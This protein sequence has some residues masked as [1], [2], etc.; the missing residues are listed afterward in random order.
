MTSP[1]CETCGK[2]YEK[3]A[4][5]QFCSSSFHCC[6]DCTWKAG[7][8]VMVCK[9]CHDRDVKIA[10]D[11]D[12]SQ[13]ST[14][15]HARLEAELR[16]SRQANASQTVAYL[17]VER[18][19]EQAKRM[20]S[21]MRDALGA[22]MDLHAATDKR[23]VVAEKRLAELEAAA[24]VVS[25]WWHR[26]DGEKHLGAAMEALD[27]ALAHAP[28]AELAN[29][30]RMATAILGDDSY[31]RVESVS[32]KVAA[33]VTSI[34]AY[35]HNAEVD[36]TQLAAVTKERD[37]AVAHD[38]Q[39]YPTA[40]AYEGACAALLAE[41]DRRRA[42][43]KRAGELEAALRKY[44]HNSHC[45]DG[46]GGEGPW[47]RRCEKVLSVM[48]GDDAMPAHALDVASATKACGYPD[49]GSWPV[50]NGGMHTGKPDCPC[51]AEPHGEFKRDGSLDTHKEKP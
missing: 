35:R 8:R 10:V 1:I 33:M 36:R 26:Q 28:E 11:W 16:E 6:H 45:D 22:E 47:C 18:E 9:D 25:K 27:T 50:E 13:R 24:R 15:P 48:D 31:A 17:E 46:C 40:D 4:A 38:R 19:L 51:D 3:N 37:L 2:P 5:A 39:P 12:R 44:W 32:L 30:D 14:I 21:T 20:F 29:I 43:E 41:R 23:A 34:H 7:V 49:N 42:A